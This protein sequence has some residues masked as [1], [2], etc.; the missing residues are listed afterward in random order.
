MIRRFGDPPHAD[1]IYRP[2]P[3]AYAVLIRG[4][5]MLTTF[6]AGPVPEFQLPGGGIDPGESPLGA[7]Y[8][9][10][11]EET[12][13]SI[14]GA[15]RLGL[16]RRFAYMPDYDLWAEKTCA[17]YAAR[18]VRRHG[19]PSEPGHS[20]HWLPVRE[21]IARLA[22]SGDRFFAARHCRGYGT[23]PRNSKRIP[24]TSSGK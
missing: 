13:W 9:E 18:P 4:D 20:A 17:I 11:R 1:R 12:G 5:R 8:R 21:A 22:S 15:V 19:P 2:R 7:L 23:A 24:D 3:G 6:Q 14:A 10:V 16:Y